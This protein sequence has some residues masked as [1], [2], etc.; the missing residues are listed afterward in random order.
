MSIFLYQAKT[1]S[2]AVRQS[3]F[4]E[5]FP[6]KLIFIHFFVC[7]IH[8]ILEVPVIIDITAVISE[9]CANGIFFARRSV[10][11]VKIVVYIFYIYLDYLLN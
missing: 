7:D 5:F 11:S 10:I 3:V 1:D 2:H 4:P 9:A 8:I 6:L